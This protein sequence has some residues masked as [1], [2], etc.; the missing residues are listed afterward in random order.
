MAGSR[1][2]FRQQQQASSTGQS[3]RGNN[4]KDQELDSSEV[5]SAADQ[6][7]G[8]YAAYTR[9]LQSSHSLSF[10]CAHPKSVGFCCG[11][12]GHECCLEDICIYHFKELVTA[13]S[14]LVSAWV[15]S[16]QMMVMPQRKTPPA[17]PPTCPLTLA[18][19]PHGMPA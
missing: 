10:V 12:A 15:M 17:V 9:R 18:W 16:L 13:H 8:E 3:K 6:T 2:H 4:A 11:L 14:N 19:Q 1:H 5:V 7:E